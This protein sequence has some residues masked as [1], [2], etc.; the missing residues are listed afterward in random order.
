MNI[1]DSIESVTT[2]IEQFHTQFLADALSESLEH[3]RSLFDGI[4]ELMAPDGWQEPISARIETEVAIDGGRIDVCLFTEEPKARVIAIEV[5]TVEDSTEPD[6]LSRYYV[7]LKKRFS[8]RDIHL[9]YL[10]PFNADRAGDK[11][12]SLQTVKEFEGFKAAHADAKDAKHLSWLDVTSIPWD[13]NALWRQH[14]DYVSRKISSETNLKAGAEQNR[15]IADFFGERAGTEFRS[16]LDELHPS[17]DGNRLTIG[18]AQLDE[19]EKAARIVVD[20]IEALL[21]GE[22]VELRE[23]HDD[24]ADD[25]RQKFLDSKHGGIHRPLFEL[26][27]RFPGVWVQ[28]KDDYGVRI[29]HR[30]HRG[31]VSALRSHGTDHL[32]VYLKR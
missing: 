10:T 21:A 9:V 26:S 4:W 27:S 2:R 11:A 19:P 15:S 25:I 28:G 29:A 7:G 30:N 17:L 20:A 8:E 1:F 24:L 22:S 5:K 16:L 14:Q 6:Q 32:V 31:G 3:D 18:L 12:H 13:G 23:C